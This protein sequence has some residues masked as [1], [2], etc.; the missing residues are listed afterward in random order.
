VMSPERLGADT[1]SSALVVGK[2]E[3]AT[4]ELLA[5]CAVLVV[6]VLNDV[7]LTTVDEAGHRHDQELN[8]EGVH[9]S[10]RTVLLRVRGDRSITWVGRHSYWIDLSSPIDGKHL[11]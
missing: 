4:N 9:G 3:T 11:A 5:Q 8:G 2:P 7:L 6:K 10:D 1:Q